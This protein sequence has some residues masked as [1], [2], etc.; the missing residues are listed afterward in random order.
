MFQQP[1]VLSLSW[2]HNYCEKIERKKE[3]TLLWPRMGFYRR[4]PPLWCRRAPDYLTSMDQAICLWPQAAVCA[5][6]NFLASVVNGFQGHITTWRNIA[7]SH[8]V[9]FVVWQTN[10]VFLCFFFPIR[11]TDLYDVDFSFLFSDLSDILFFICKNVWI[12]LRY[13]IT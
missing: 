3:K 5:L 4:R 1:L 13:L 12:N 6:E 10:Q 11:L 8:H 9:L 2:W 7:V